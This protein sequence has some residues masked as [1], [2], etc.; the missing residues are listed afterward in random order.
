MKCKVIVN[1]RM[2]RGYAYYRTEPVGR[3]FDP[4]FRPELTPKEMLRLGVFGGKYMTDCRR[5][6]P[7][8]WFVHAKLCSARHDPKLNYFGVNASQSLATWRRHGWIRAQDPRGWFQWYCRYYLG[9][10][11]A[12]DARQIRRWRAIARHVAA[13]R[14]HCAKGD[15]ECRRRQRQAVLHW[16]YDSR[17]I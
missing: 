4:L 17:R 14:K 11:S 5:E 7:A 9:R 15:L 1:D 12:D 3:H 6:F 10:R 13:I 8:S 16:A 2:Q